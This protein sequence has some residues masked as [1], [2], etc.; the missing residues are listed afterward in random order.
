MKIEMR[1]KYGRMAGFTLLEMLVVLVIMGMLVGLVGPRLFSKVDS[2][3][4]Q[5]ATAQIKLLRGAVE[6]MRLE[7][8]VY[9][10]Q[11]QGLS[12]LVKAPADQALRAK[13][14]GP[15]LEDAVPNDPWDR[16]YQYMV[17]GK[18]GKPFT[19][20][21]FG[22]DGKQG[23]EGNNADIGLGSGTAESTLTQ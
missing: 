9:P 6:T 7:I 23:G 19:I 22:A 20:Y 14:H 1:E 17:P 18:D 11:E 13:W 8:G 21:S 15:Y 16:P 3:K 10:T 5:T 2:S 12:L 4:V